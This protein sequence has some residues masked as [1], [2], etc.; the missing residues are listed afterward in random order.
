MYAEESLCFYEYKNN[1]FR[2]NQLC[3]K[4]IENYPSV[5]FKKLNN[6]KRIE[7]LKKSEAVSVKTYQSALLSKESINYYFNNS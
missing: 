2:Y 7:S 6:S 5:K 1:N 4:I 3:E